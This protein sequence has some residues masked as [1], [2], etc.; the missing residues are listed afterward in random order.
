MYVE[1]GLL[2]TY[3]LVMHIERGLLCFCPQVVHSEFE[4]KVCIAIE[5]Y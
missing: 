2:F 5:I 1:R 3:Q 4:A